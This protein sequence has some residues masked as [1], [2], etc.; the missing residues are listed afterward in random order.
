MH[1]QLIAMTKFT[2]KHLEYTAEGV[3]STILPFRPAQN[4]FGIT[5][6]IQAFKLSMFISG[7]LNTDAQASVS[8]L[9]TETSVLRLLGNGYLKIIYFIIKKE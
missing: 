8:T 2:K 7:F 4:P 3:I 1:W 5:F 6:F 9:M